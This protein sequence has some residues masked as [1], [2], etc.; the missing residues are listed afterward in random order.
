MGPH[1]GR[2]QEPVA[3]ESSID[4]SKL[5]AGLAAAL[6]RRPD[7]AQRYHVTIRFASVLDDTARVSLAARGVKVISPGVGTG[8]LS[9]EDVAALSHRPEVARLSLAQ[10]LIRSRQH[11]LG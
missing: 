3:T 9:I 8:H 4:F 2:P 11:S 6:G 10:R 7:E 1:G 5:D